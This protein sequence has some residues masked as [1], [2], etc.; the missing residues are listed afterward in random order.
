MFKIFFLPISK[1]LI[2]LLLDTNL[3]ESRFFINRQK[4]IALATSQRKDKE[5]L[6]ILPRKAKP[7]ARVRDIVLDSLPKCN[8]ARAFKREFRNVCG[9]LVTCYALYAIVQHKKQCYVSFMHYIMTLCTLSSFSRT[10]IMA[11]RGGESV[12]ATCQTAAIVKS[13]KRFRI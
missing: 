4:I 10:F 2:A 13:E 9:A 11:W 6:F 8:T 7:R 5:S 1:T 3:K 12:H